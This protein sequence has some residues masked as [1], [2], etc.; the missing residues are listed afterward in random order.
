MPCIERSVPSLCE[1]QG[2]SPSTATLSSHDTIQTIQMLPVCRGGAMYLVCEQTQV[3]HDA[4][5]RPVT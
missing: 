5:E 3:G 1:M 4:S 2:T